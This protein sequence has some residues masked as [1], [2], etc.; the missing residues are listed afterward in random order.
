MACFILNLTFF[1]VFNQYFSINF[2]KSFIAVISNHPIALRFWT[3]EHI[4][5]ETD[6]IYENSYFKH[7]FLIIFNQ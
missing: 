2:Y 7:K 4:I 3:V 1:E 6:K 5:M